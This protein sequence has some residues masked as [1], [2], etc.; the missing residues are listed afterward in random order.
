MRASVGLSL[1]LGAALAAGCSYDL[2][3]LR[4][5]RDA[6]TD[7]GAPVDTG[8]PPVDAGPRDTGPAEDRP[9]PERDA[10]AGS[11]ALDAGLSPL[12]LGTAGALLDDNTNRPEVTSVP[13][14]NTTAGC[15]EQDTEGP[16]RSRVYRIEVRRA[17]RLTVSTHTGL[18]N[19]FDTRV[20]LV[21]GCS[22]AEAQPPLACADD[23]GPTDPLR[24]SNCPSTD[25]PNNT[26]GCFGLLSTAHVDAVPGDRIFAVVHGYRMTRGNFRLW[27][28]ENAALIEPFNPTASFTVDR[29]AC[30]GPAGTR[31]EFNFPSSAM[32]SNSVTL[33]TGTQGVLH[34]VAIPT[35]FYQGVSA[36]FRLKLNLSAEA[37]CL[38]AAQRKVVLDLFIGSRVV[39]AFSLDV[40]NRS[41][42][43]SVP[44][45]AFR[46]QQITSPGNLGF[47]LRQRSE[48]PV[49]GQCLRVEVEPGPD[50][51]VALYQGTAP[52]A[53]M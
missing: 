26:S 49:D 30:L 33:S 31:R 42:I 46:P 13:L 38:M 52:D 44:Y 37:R 47:E 53:G 32:V 10:H 39:T 24:C 18:C 20:Q 51:V 7:R 15:T 11:C 40:R 19:T 3:A 27:A 6:A 25:M 48:E 43:V 34:A 9:L 17:G 5:N 22:M 16:Q 41:G 45:T 50:N 4:G 8:P 2:D 14:L 21:R 35:G 23:L 29:C 36:Q 1:A 12:S 28:G